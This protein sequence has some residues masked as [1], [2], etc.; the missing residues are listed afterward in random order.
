MKP[1]KILIVEDHT[2]YAKGIESILPSLGPFIITGHATQLNAAYNAIIRHQPDI[3]L[4]DVRLGDENGLDLVDLCREQNLGCKFIII[5]AHDSYT[6]KVKAEKKGVWAVLPKLV[7]AEELVKTIQE[8]YQN[9][10]QKKTPKNN[11]IVKQLL[12]ES[13]NIRQIEVC[14]L[15]LDGNTKKEIATIL[16]R[17]PHT[18][19][20]QIRAIY[21]KLGISSR[22]ELEKLKHK[23]GTGE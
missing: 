9:T 5:S 1:C 13:L 15:L 11:H 12:L 3:V 7:R 16:Q 19:D 22:E 20:S 8:V 2:F 23:L 17:S 10:Y 18:V 4:L 6:L 21:H 14:Q